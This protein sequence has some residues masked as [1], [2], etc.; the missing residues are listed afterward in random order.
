MPTQTPTV[1][2]QRFLR[3]APH[4]VYRA[5]LDPDLVRRWMAPVEYDVTRS[6]VDERVG[7]RHRVWQTGP[8]G[9]E[10][11]GFDSELVE[12][13]PDERIVFSWRFVGPDREADPTHDS[14]LT[15]DLQPAADGG[16]ILTLVH[17]KLDALAE[18]TPEVAAGVEGGWTGTLGRLSTTLGGA[19]RSPGAVLDQES[20]DAVLND[21]VSQRL[22]TAAMPTRLAYT[23][24]DGSPRVIPIATWWSGSHLVIGTIPSSPKVAALQ[25][26]PRVAL[27]F[28]TEGFPPNILLLRGTAELER[29]EG[30]PEEYLA[31]G[32]KTVPAADYP[33]WEAQVRELYEEMVLITI[34]PSWAKVMDF[35]TRIPRAVE[36]LATAKYGPR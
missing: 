8:D 10:V 29:V 17:E 19:D 31:G 24:I 26:D 15:I 21:P 34:T 33:A 27:T 5:W 4:R 2:I 14:T 7:G 6:E 22:L 23:G 18:A 35:K 3:A 36:E 11:G 20:L 16:T 12:L 32:R 13:V 30:L 1:R 25:Q 28:D 9:A